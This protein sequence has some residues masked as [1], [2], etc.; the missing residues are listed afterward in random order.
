M[1]ALNIEGAV[2][3]RGDRMAVA[4]IDLK[5]AAGERVAL[6]G[7]NGA[8]KTTLMRLIL[9]LTSLDAGSITLF[10]HVPGSGAA[11]RITA[12][13]P[14]NIA[15]HPA[16]SGREQLRHFARLRGETAARADDLLAR[17]G[18]EKDADR[19][20]RTYSKGMCQRLGLAQ[21]LLGE[22]RLT[23]FDEPTSGLDPVARWQFYDLID[24]IAATGG[25]VLLSSHALTE[26]EAKTDRIAILRQGRLVANDRIEALRR[27]AGLPVTLRVKSRPGRV[28]GL[29]NRLGG[30]RLNGSAI[31]L[32]CG[33][34]E[35]IDR[36]AAVHA[37]R[38]MVEDIDIIPPDLDDLYRHYS[39][40]EGDSA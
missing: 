32:Q 5:I 22:P 39:A 37:V 19:R 24:E 12:Y 40:A 17:V 8:G 9:G 2:K 10:G 4:E 25:T 38:E 7:H 20:V 28:D 14:E 34:S 1:N 23:L 13:L 33:A 36:L 27:K 26:M 21:A 16:L 30:R 31:E 11:R 3:W 18:L 15:F 29:L 6:L 35:K